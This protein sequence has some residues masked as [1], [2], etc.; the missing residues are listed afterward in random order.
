MPGK[1]RRYADGGKVRTYGAPMGPAKKKPGGRPKAGPA[2][3]ETRRK[4]I[5]EK[6]SSSSSKSSSSTSRN[7]NKKK[8]SKTPTSDLRATTAGKRVSGR[9]RQI[10]KAV[11][12]AVKGK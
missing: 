3:S 2:D 4:K 1:K 12:S 10:D 7:R 8:D 11:E 9:G 6:T 5:K